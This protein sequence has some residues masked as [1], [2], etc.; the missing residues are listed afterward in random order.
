LQKDPK[1]YSDSMNLY[2]GFGMNPMNFIDPFGTKIKTEDLFELKR[3][4][5]T[6]GV[7]AAKRWIDKNPNFTYGEKVDLH[8]K[9]WFG[10]D[11]PDAE[12]DINY[13]P[14]WDEFC[15]FIDEAAY[16]SSKPY[17]KFHYGVK[18]RRHDIALQGLTEIVTAGV[19]SG[20]ILYAAPELINF[21]TEKFPVLK[22]EIRII[23]GKNPVTNKLRKGSGFKNDNV[24]PI[25]NDKSQIIKEFPAKSKAHGFN[26]ILDN[27]AKKGAY[28]R[29]RKDAVLIQIKGIY[30]G[31]PG[32]FEWIID[33]GRV[34]HRMFV[35]GGRINGIPIVEWLFEKN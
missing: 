12:S 23:K 35:E 5:N 26:D 6:K 31:V 29:I 15:F 20:V 7:D 16:Q 14:V 27:Y 33:K 1:G 9:V 28:F 34:T 4:F 13:I 24:K 8:M 2:Q 10:F 11:D 18:H 21:L 19:I 25:R 32:R 22:R 30:N 3:I 17:L